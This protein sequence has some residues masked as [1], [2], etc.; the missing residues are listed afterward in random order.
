[1]KK[2][3]LFVINT[4][5]RAGAETALLE[6]LRQV[7]PE[8][9]E[10]SLFVLTGQG[11]LA[12]ELPPYV[13]LLN[14]D[15]DNTSVLSRVGKRKLI[16]RVFR[17]MCARG[18]VIRL[19]PYLFRNLWRM[20]GDRAVNAEKLLWRVLSDGAPR[21][22][23]SYDLAVSYLE[24]GSTYYVADHVKAAHKAAFVHIDYTMAGYTR[25]LDL[26]C[27]R[28]MDKIFAVSDEVRSR[29]LEVY[30]ENGRKLEVFHNILNIS[31][32]HR[33]SRLSGGFTDG[34]GGTRILTI[35]RLTAQKAF[36]VS[37][38]ALKLL[39]DAGGRFRWYVLGEGDQRSRLQ[40]KIGA[41]G[42]T[43]DFI[44]CGAVDN[45]YPYLAQA[46]LYVHASRFEGKSI[47]VQEA[48]ILG[49]PVLASDCSGN[50]E[51][52]SDGE[53]GKLCPFT[54]EGIRNG[55]LWLM[56]HPEERAKYVRAAGQKYQE[57]TNG[58][59]KLLSLV[60]ENEG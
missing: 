12:S 41:L 9:Y 25:A 53:D 49:C 36:E 39:K 20:L 6:I 7:P 4:L 47:A 18:T 1:M 60:G 5:S 17:S 42:L 14:T 27:Y 8:R 11:E 22:D 28:E 15:Y 13:R 40:R 59:G 54:P 34:Y 37:V 21:W 26:D 32:I 51:N 45:P 3:L 10:V 19:F 29:F 50:R 52:V 30:P 58:V 48:Q 2:K 24:G 43:E 38:E 57:Q 23:R 55:I 46:D 35:G 16:E 31:E 44:L 33:K 56:E